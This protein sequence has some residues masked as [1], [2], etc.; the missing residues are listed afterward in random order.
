MSAQQA[1]AAKG[2]KVTGKATAGTRP[3]PGV[4]VVIRTRRADRRGDLHRARRHLP[5][6]PA[7]RRQLSRVGRADRIRQ[8]R[9]RNRPRWRPPLPCESTADFALD[10]ESARFA[11]SSG[12]TGST[13]PAGARAG[14][15]ARFETLAVQADADRRG[16]PGRES[17]RPRADGS[18]RARAAAAGFH[19]RDSDRSRGDDR[20]HGQHRPRHDERPH[21]GDR[22]WRVRSGHR[23]VRCGAGSGRAAAA[24]PG[25]GRPGMVRADAAVLA[26]REVL[27][28]RRRVPA[29]AAVRASAGA[30]CSSGSTT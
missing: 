10:S 14:G 19:D 22:P 23:T 17:A 29:D 2:C 20:Q 24:G 26:G 27:E 1:A 9:A 6:L 12:S 8:V 16:G 13:G 7:A 4:A 18:R 3:L 30:A 28:A 11:G 25:T 21:A 15:P 5:A